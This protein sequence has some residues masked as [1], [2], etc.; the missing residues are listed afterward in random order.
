MPSSL[1][2]SFPRGQDGEEVERW[3]CSVQQKEKGEVVV[4]R[5]TWSPARVLCGLSGPRLLSSDWLGR[6]SGLIFSAL[7]CPKYLNP[8]T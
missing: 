5:V 4:D 7:R 2:P 8:D 1:S 3:L 6:P